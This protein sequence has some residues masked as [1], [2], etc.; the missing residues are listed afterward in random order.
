[1][2]IMIIILLNAFL[3]F[4]QEF[5]S[6]K[7]IEK[8][9]GLIGRKQ[10]NN[11]SKITQHQKTLTEFSFVIMKIIVITVLFMLMIKVFSIHNAG[12]F[13]EI[14]LFAIALVMTV[15]PE[16]LP[17]ITTVTLSHGALKLA[18]QKLLAKR[19]T[20]IE[21]LGRID[22]LCIDLKDSD[23]MDANI[24]NTKNKAFHK[25]LKI[26][27]KRAKKLGLKLKIFTEDD[28]E[29][30]HKYR[31]L[32]LL[33]KKGYIVGYQCSNTKDTLALGLAD[34]SITTEETES[35]AKNTA[36]IVLLENNPQVTINGILFGRSIFVN[37]N[38]Y[39]QHAMIGNFGSFFSMIFFYIVFAADIPMLAIQVLIGNIIQDLPLMAISSDSVNIEEV[40]KPQAGG[41]VSKAET[42]LMSMKTF[43][44]KQFCTM[45][46][47]K[48]ISLKGF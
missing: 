38:K 40:N 7:A 21:D 10:R 37:I 41:E 45:L 15:V 8:L 43:T 35:A 13:A 24:M 6:G 36:D 34:V 19:L 20:S 30:G 14:I 1:M 42:L 44:L 11:D 22:V 33:K 23:D 31:A 17:M 28:K 18:K 32:H 29:S 46:T 27:M 12:D 25:K 26:S 39:I 48:I 9:Y 47:Q 16:A 5:R 3:G 4:V 2:I